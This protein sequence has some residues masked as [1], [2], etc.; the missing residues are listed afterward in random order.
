[1]TSQTKYTLQA[2]SFAGLALSIIPA[3]LVFG[4]MLS[5]E[6]YLHLM[7][8]GMLLWFCTAIFWIRKD[9]LG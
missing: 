9:H 5:R 4:G 1:M 8:T 3:F 6:I 2:I 7:V